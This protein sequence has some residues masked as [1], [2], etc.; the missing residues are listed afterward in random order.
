MTDH[1]GGTVQPLSLLDELLEAERK[2]LEQYRTRAKEE[3]DPELR[4]IL[5]DLLSAR[6]RYY[7]RLE[8]RRRAQDATAV[9]TRQIN[10]LYR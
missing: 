3:P 5:D 7:A 9:I 8:E 2:L 1:K 4:Q 6:R 10:D